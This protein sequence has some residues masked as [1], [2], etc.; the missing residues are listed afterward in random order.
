M[1]NPPSRFT[2]ERL[3]V[4]AAQNSFKR[5]LTGTVADY[6]GHD[7][8]AGHYRFGVF[9]GATRRL[10]E[11]RL[12]LG[13]QNAAGV[14]RWSRIVA[15]APQ[16]SYVGIVC[17]SLTRHYGDGRGVSDRRASRTS[18]AARSAACKAPST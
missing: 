16:S 2:V 11:E 4:D 15:L 8:C 3:H 14:R 5:D 10:P 6:L 9:V 18:V 12:A 13:C 1:S 17:G 7:R